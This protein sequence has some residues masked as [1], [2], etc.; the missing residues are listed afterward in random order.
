MP[1]TTTT[2]TAGSAG[3]AGPRPA[4]K[5][6][7]DIAI[8]VHAGAVS[9]GEPALEVGRGEGLKLSPRKWAEG[10]GDLK[11]LVR[12]ELAPQDAETREAVLERLAASTAIQGDSSFELSA[13]LY[14]IREVLRER[15]PRCEVSE[16][17]PAGLAVG[18]ILAVDERSFW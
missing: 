18:E 11:V 13:S 15:L 2:R 1:R 9:G 7:S 16:S 10:E 14:G 5:L 6:A 4:A 8:L 17:Q 3:A 12:E